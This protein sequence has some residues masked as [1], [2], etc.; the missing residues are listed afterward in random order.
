MSGYK[1]KWNGQQVIKLSE[2]ATELA[3][4]HI[5]IDVHREAVRNAPV[6]TGRLKGSLAYSVNGDN[7][8]GSGPVETSKP[9]D[10]KIKSNKNMAIVGTNVGYAIKMEY[11]GSKQAPKGYLRPASDKVRL[12][13][14]KIVQ[15]YFKKELG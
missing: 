5:A 3:I 13:I 9:N 2:K 6:D 12:T 15:K 10:D 8:K 11:G 14:P 4:E 1:L 7:S